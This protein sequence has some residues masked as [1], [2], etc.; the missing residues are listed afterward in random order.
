MGARLLARDRAVGVCWIL[1]PDDDEGD[2]DY[3]LRR[4]GGAACASELN[5]QF[6]VGSFVGFVAG[7]VE[8]RCIHRHG[9]QQRRYRETGDQLACA[10][11]TERVEHS[12]HLTALIADGFDLDG[13]VFEAKPKGARLFPKC[14]IQNR[15]VDLGHSPTHVA[16][17]ELTAVILFSAITMGFPLQRRVIL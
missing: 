13:A 14:A 6:A 17:Q 11:L 8:M 10:R 5:A 1:T 15:I 3:E 4:Y 9:E 16:H 2:A 7:A 12:A